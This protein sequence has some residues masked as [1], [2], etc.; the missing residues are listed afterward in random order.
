MK[1]SPSLPFGGATGLLRL[2]SQQRGSPRPPFGG[3]IFLNVDSR[4]VLSDSGNVDSRQG[5]II[6]L[7]FI[8]LKII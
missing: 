3:D 6:F 7:F 1:G 5:P 2:T 4:H 8:G